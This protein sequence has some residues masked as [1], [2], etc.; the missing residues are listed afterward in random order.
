MLAFPGQEATHT[1]QL[2]V[3]ILHCLNRLSKQLAVVVGESTPEGDQY[4]LANAYHPGLRNL[5]DS[6]LATGNGSIIRLL[7]MPSS[8]VVRRT[9]AP[10]A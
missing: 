10:Q 7:R 4:P 3:N 1:L 6:E 8:A 2:L 9:S 5:P